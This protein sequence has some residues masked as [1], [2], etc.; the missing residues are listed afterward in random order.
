MTSESPHSDHSQPVPVLTPPKTG[1]LWTL[2]GRELSFSFHR[3]Q[4]EAWDCEARFPFILA[5]AQSGKTAFEPWWLAREIGRTADINGG[6]NDYLA[7]TATFDLFKLKFLP[8][9]LTC[10]ED[11]LGN[12]RYWAGDRIIEL[13]D[14]RTGRFWA[15][16][17]KDRMWGRIIC[18]AA[19]AGGGLE[20]TTGRGAIMDE[21]GMPEY[22]IETFESVRRRMALH[23]GRIL[24]GTTLYDLGWLKT[25]VYDA[26]MRIGTPHEREGD[27]EFAVINFDST[28]NPA[29][30]VEEFEAARRSMPLWRF[31]MMYRGI[32]TRPAGQIYDCWVDADVSEGGHR[33]R[34]APIPE[35]WHKVAGLDFGVV[36]T[37]IGVY[38]VEEDAG[39]YPTGRLLLFRTYHAGAQN[40][41]GHIEALHAIE[42]NIVLAT[43]GA[44]SEDSWR[45]AYTWGGLPVYRPAVGDLEVGI[46]RMYGAIKS[47]R[48][49]TFDTERAW[50]EQIKDYSRELD[51]TGTPTQKIKDKE[52]FHH[53]D[54]SRY[55][56]LLM[57]PPAPFLPFEPRRDLLVGD[58]A[59]R[60]I[61][62]EWQRFG[63]VFYE[64]GGP[65]AF[66]LCAC[67]PG[68]TVIVEREYTCIGTGW[69]IFAE[70]MHDMLYE[71]RV[72]IAVARPLT[73][74]GD[75]GP[76]F[77]IGGNATMFITS[78][79]GVT[80]PSV[81]DGL[82]SKG[83]PITKVTGD[84][85]NEWSNCSDWL[86][87]GK[88][89]IN[90][91]TC[92]FL[93]L[94]LGLIVS[95]VKYP[96]RP[97]TRGPI[98]AAQALCNALMLRPKPRKL[99]IGERGPRLIPD[100]KLPE[101]LRS[102][103][104]GDVERFE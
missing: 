43:G 6:D 78:R 56:C 101:A 37:A 87:S 54:S 85:A 38:A 25:V 70:R 1:G 18:R 64:E 77:R 30:P 26:W 65:C 88:L 66:V 62:S 49:L 47:A 10:F 14:Q 32:Y 42:P 53:L 35:Q 21:C 48:L 92:P 13:R 71:H 80:T 90:R 81:A 46:D 60:A 58:R 39:G 50:I 34:P 86:L 99:T 27:R 24:G 69:R 12:G 98:S 75:T 23:Q 63:G 17:S 102:N 2:D 28:E 91:Q 96:E 7:V 93:S 19:S 9:L 76:Q 41:T 51:D 89:R 16:K 83:L 8:E 5:G 59:R 44:R 84:K 74:T 103:K 82:R 79:D 68:G 52:K 11:V 61:P 15:K 55:L 97:D 67:S 73:N 29:F 3:G 100:R 33:M 40:A 36:N 4:G 104:R 20:S 45:Q 72:P 31:N 57:F 22:T 95:D 94:T